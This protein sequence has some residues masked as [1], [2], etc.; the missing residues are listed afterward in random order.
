[1]F[2]GV[3]VSFLLEV[4]GKQVFTFS[5]LVKSENRRSNQFAN[6]HPRKWLTY[7][8]VLPRVSVMEG[9]LLDPMRH[10]RHFT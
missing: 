4:K 10:L 3:K 8:C 7:L 9:R 2:H 6:L 5:L 1:M